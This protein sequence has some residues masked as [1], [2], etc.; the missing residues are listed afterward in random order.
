MSHVESVRQ[1]SIRHKAVTLFA[2]TSLLPLLLFLLTL[3]R[4]DLLHDTEATLMLAM[5]IMIAVLGFVLFLQM[6][7]RISTL[8]NNVLRL[9]K[10]ELV[11]LTLDEASHE[12]T[13]MSYIA[14]T[15]Q[16]LLS[17][18]QENTHNLENIVYKLSTL[19]EVTE[20]AASIPD[21]RDILDIVL[22]RAIAVV[23]AENGSIMLLDEPT[24]TLKVVA[25]EGVAAGSIEGMTVRLGEGIAG[26]VA[27]SGD[28]VL[29]ND[30]E[31]EPSFLMP[32]HPN[33]AAS[34]FLCMPLRSR[35]R[36]IGV[37]NLAKKGEHQIFSESDRKFLS[38]LLGHIGFAVDNAKLLQEAKE[39]TR[40]FLQMT[41]E[42]HGQEAAGQQQPQD[43]P[44]P[45]LA[46][47]GHELQPSLTNALGYAQ[48]LMNKVEIDTK[49]HTTAKH[50]FADIRRAV[51]TVRNLLYFAEPASP[52]MQTEHLNDILTRVLEVKA[53]DLQISKIEVR[54]DLAPDLPPV[55][56]DAQ[57]VQQA[58]L[59]ILS[60]ARQ[61]MVKQGPLRRLSVS[62]RQEG[63]LLRA[64]ITDTGSG[65][66]PEDVE[67]IFTPFFSTKT[68]GKGMGLG[69]SI[70]SQIITAH[71]GEISMTTHGGEGTTICVLLPMTHPS[72]RETE[73][74][75]S[76]AN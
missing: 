38:T 52:Y 73:S 24:G 5:G 63:Q 50:L 9:E 32:D 57:Q 29:V 39:S 21:T 23:Q 51:R 37:L 14:E 62:T 42:S 46:H 45:L 6:V 55:M 10:G 2:L 66:A 75:M 13:E 72:P 59:H 27:A 58:F 68:Q 1:Y 31:Q 60:N 22:Q 71:H 36:V 67:K 44:F 8:A 3:D 33:Y 65:I 17:N 35:G 64:D 28:A 76:A 25:E 12:L 49:L 34:S 48:W 41:G 69:L 4:K 53:Y 30:V 26:K 18:L 15:F 16:K 11:A 47:I 19:S 20:L 61:A 7:Q 54:A 70:A 40:K 43:I 74:A 56:V